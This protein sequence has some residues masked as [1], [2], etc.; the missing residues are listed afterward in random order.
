LNVLVISE[1]KDTREYKIK[2]ERLREMER[3]KR[4]NEK[5]KYI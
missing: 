4:E 3:A 1:K 2:R 5:K